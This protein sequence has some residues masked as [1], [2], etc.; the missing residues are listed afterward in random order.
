[1]KYFRTYHLPF[2]KGATSDDK[3]SVDYSFLENNETVILEKLDG[4]N[5]CM[6][7]HDIFARSHATPSELPWDKPIKEIQ[8]RVNRSIADNEYVFGESMVGIHSIEYKKLESYFYIF[9]I[10]VGE[11]WLSWDDVQDYAYCLD[12][13]TVPVLKR[14]IFTCLKK[15]VEN[16]IIQPSTF[17]GYD[18]ITGEEI[19]EGVVVRKTNSFMNSDSKKNLLKYVRAGHVKTDEHWTRNWK[20][21]KL[22]Y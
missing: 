12:L 16:I 9:G 1:M 15:E 14:G 8:Q 20:K 22:I 2:S 5:S 7:K 21:C 17:D 19:M 11:E 3:I 13:P 10:R 6:S 18:V 4:Q